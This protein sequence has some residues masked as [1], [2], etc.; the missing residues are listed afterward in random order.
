MDRAPLPHAPLNH[1]ANCETSTAA[2]LRTGPAAGSLLSPGLGLERLLASA[3]VRRP[4]GTLR[5]RSLQP[6]GGL[7]ASLFL[8][9]PPSC[10][11]FGNNQG[12]EMS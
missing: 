6:V 4:S 12:P 10:M 9:H 7:W 1:S 5:G 8:C 3:G 11:L 2:L